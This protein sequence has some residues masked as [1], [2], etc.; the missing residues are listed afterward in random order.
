MSSFLDQTCGGGKGRPLGFENTSPAFLIFLTGLIGS[1]LVLV[2]E[3]MVGR[4][5]KKIKREEENSNEDNKEKRK[6]FVY[7][8]SQKQS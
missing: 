8:V 5:E 6:A 3:I 4:K 1:W 7:E 2:G